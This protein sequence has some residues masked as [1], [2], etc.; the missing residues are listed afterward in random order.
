MNG[1]IR[2]CYVSPLLHHPRPWRNDLK[3]VQRALAGAASFRRMHAEMQFAAMRGRLSDFLAERQ[4]LFGKTHV[5][6]VEKLE[7]TDEYPDP[8]G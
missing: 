5:N 3:A 4:L 7:H 8:P 6:S 2:H 1:A